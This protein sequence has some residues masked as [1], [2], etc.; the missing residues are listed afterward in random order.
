MNKTSQVE[1]KEH[2]I[3]DHKKIY[4]INLTS[5]KLKNN[6]EVFVKTQSWIQICG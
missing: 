4:S 1:T 3:Q 6:S 5:N 2:F